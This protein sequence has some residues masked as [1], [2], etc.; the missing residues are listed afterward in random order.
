MFKKSTPNY[1]DFIDGDIAGNTLKL[2]KF[3]ESRSNSD[4]KNSIKVIAMTEKLG[5]IHTHE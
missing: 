5:R 1:P 4:I 3:F 2:M